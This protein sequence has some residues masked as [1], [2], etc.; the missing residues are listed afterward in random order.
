MATDRV[1]TMQI[2]AR[3][4]QKVSLF[5]IEAMMGDSQVSGDTDT[6]EHEQCENRTNPQE[7]QSLCKSESHKSK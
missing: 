1:H 3:H 5:C 7:R 6:E 2:T 4:V